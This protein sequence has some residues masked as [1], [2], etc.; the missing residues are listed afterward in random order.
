M[1]GFQDVD[2]L[3]CIRLRQ[4]TDNAPQKRESPC[5]WHTEDAHVVPAVA[6][7]TSTSTSATAAAAIPTAPQYNNCEPTRLYYCNS[8]EYLGTER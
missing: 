6:V 4:A 1:L 5:F 7:S 8:T 3:A 2:L